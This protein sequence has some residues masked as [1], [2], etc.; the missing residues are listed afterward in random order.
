LPR[1]EFMKKSASSGSGGL[2]FTSRDYPVWR[3][4]FEVSVSAPYGFP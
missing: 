1:R 2:G 3:F 4:G